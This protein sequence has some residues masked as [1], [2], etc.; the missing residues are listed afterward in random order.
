MGLGLRMAEDV[1][2]HRKKVYHSTPSIED[3]LWRRA[4][5]CGRGS[6]SPACLEALTFADAIYLGP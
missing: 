6:L 5:W 3:E 1:G 4:V 2:A